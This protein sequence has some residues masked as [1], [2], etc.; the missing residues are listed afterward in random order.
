MKTSAMTVNPKF[1]RRRRV[2]ASRSFGSGSGGSQTRRM[3]VR[4][5]MKIDPC[6]FGGYYNNCVAG[7]KRDWIHVSAIANEVKIAAVRIL[8][9]TPAPIKKASNPCESEAIS[10]DTSYFLFGSFSVP[11]RYSVIGVAHTAAYIHEATAAAVVKCASATGMIRESG[12]RGNEA[13]Y[14]YVL[15]QTPQIV[16]ETPNRRLGEDA[17]GF[18]ERSGGNKGFRSQR[19]LGDAQ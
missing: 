18:L 8:G 10:L 14:D 2:W 11:R 15:L 5:N 9:L 16:L 6:W 4:N 17:G 12:A 1:P 7:Q 13:P 3:A 19:C